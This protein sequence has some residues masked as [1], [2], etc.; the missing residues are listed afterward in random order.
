[1]KALRI[2]ALIAG[3]LFAQETIAPYVPTPAIVVTRMLKLGELKRGETMFDLGSGDGRIVIEAAKK[4]GAQAIG[5]ELDADLV[6]QSR[7]KIE[8]AK[9]SGKA[10]IIEGDLLKQDYSSADLVTIYLYPEAV[11]K[12]RPLLE[13][14]LKKGSRVVVHDFEIQRW[15][16]DRTEVVENDG[17]GRSH[18]IFLY[19]R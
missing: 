19:R 6:R 11:E 12:V 3:G 9:V 17:A 16:P 14:Q 5:V 1:M 10:R 7:A 13:A 15:Q 18:T 4:F 2:C 8:K